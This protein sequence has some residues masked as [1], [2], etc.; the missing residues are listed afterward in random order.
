MLLL[1]GLALL[2][3]ILLQLLVMLIAFGLGQD[4]TALMSGGDRQNGGTSF[5]HYITLATGSIGTFLLP[6]YVLQRR[7]PQYTFFPSFN[8]RNILLY[9][10]PLLFL[11]ISTP[12]MSLI[13]EWNMQMT[14]PDIFD[15]VEHW[16]RTQEDAMGEIT[17]NTVMVTTWDKFV[18]NILVIAVLPAIAEEFFFRGALQ[19]IFQRILKNHHATIWIVSIIFSAIHFQFYGF[20]PRLFLGVVFGYTVFWTGNIWTAIVAHFVNNA[21]VVI[22]AFYYAKQGKDYSTLMETDTYAIITYL[23]SFVFSVIIAIVFY[24][25][26]NKKKLYGKRLG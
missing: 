9:L 26:A 5:L 18:M 22:L 13:A 21:A 12:L 11:S 23:G 15:R 4:I 8:A 3:T 20:F 16:M 2:C 14:L 1:F 25:Y 19:N 10:F 24:Q 7:R 17:A 6:A